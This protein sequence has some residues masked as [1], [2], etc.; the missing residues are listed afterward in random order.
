MVCRFWFWV[1]SIYAFN[2]ITIT[3]MPHKFVKNT[4]YY[5]GVVFE[6][7]LPTGSTCPFTL[8]CYGNQ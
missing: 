2:E 1:F 5:T 7:N 8:E 4:K 3:T 6:W